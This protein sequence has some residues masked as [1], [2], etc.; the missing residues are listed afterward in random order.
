MTK[1]HSK[2]DTITGTV[3][4]MMDGSSIPGVNVVVKGSA[5]GTITDIDGRYSLDIVGEGSI[6]VFSYVG[7]STEEVEIQGRTVIDMILAESLEALNEIVVTGLS[8]ER[9][10]ESLGYSV[11]QVSGD[12]VNNVKADNFAN[13]LSG[14]V[15]GLQITESSTGVGGSSR[16]VL[17]GISSM[18]GNNRPLFVIDG[19]PMI[20]NFN[21]GNSPGKD[22]GDALADINPEDIESVTV[23]KGAG[24]AAIY[25]SRGANGV[26]LITT[27]KG[28]LNKGLGVSFNTS[29]A[30][31]EPMVMPDLQN[32][33]GQGGLG[34]RYPIVNPNITVLDHP[35]IW[36]YGPEMDGT[37]RVSWT[38]ER[39]PYVPQEDQLNYYL[40]KGNSLINNL[41]F[42]AGNENS[43]LRVSI[44]DQRDKGI[45]PNNN[46]SRQ[47]FN[48]RGFTKVKDILEI[49]GKV[50]YVHHNVENRPL[51]QENGGNAPLSFSILP[52]NISAQSLQENTV[53][54]FGNEMTWA[55][56][57]T[58]GNPYWA[59][60]NQGNYDIKDRYQ[61]AFSVK[62]NITDK[63]FLLL[64]S[65][66]DQFSLEEKSWTNKGSKTSYNGRGGYSHDLSKS[67]EWNSDFL[68]NYGNTFGKHTYGLGFGGNYR[69]NEFNTIG[70]NGSGLKIPGYYNISN[71]S[72][73][74][75]SESS[76]RKDVA[77]LYA[78]GNFSYSDILYFDFTYR[79]DWSSALPSDRNR[80]SFYSGNVSWMFTN[81]FALPR[82]ISSGKLRGSIAQ[83]G[84]D[85]GPYNLESVYGINQS[86]LPYSMVGIPGELLTPDLLPE[87]T[88][89]WEVGTDIGMFEDRLM[90]D[91]SYYYS[92]AKNQ[93][94]P[95]PLPVSTGYY[96]KRLNSGELQ[97]SG[98][99]LQISGRIL[100]NPSGFGWDMVLNYTKN[101]SNVKSINP[102]LESIQLNG[103]W[104]AV[105]LAT[106]GQEYGQIYG[107][108]YKRDEKGNMLIDEQGFPQQGDLVVHGSINPDYLFGFA[109]TFTYK[110]F[111]LNFLIDGTMGS[112]IYSWGKTYKMLW[113]TDAETLEGRAEWFDTHD[114]NGFPLPG[115]EP[116]GYI[117]PG[118]KESSGEPNTT[119]NF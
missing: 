69:I 52:R 112:E 86:P 5:S 84:N 33:Y 70:Q 48:V 78:L 109:N 64:R 17:R 12:A 95:V 2:S 23:L 41:S 3:T 72:E 119:S 10:R 50:T 60:D 98:I 115:V 110:N 1:R 65:G 105:I 27:K 62:T 63:L 6:L 20:A 103:A 14:K 107:F 104:H 96:S 75:T 116:S 118:V 80:Y 45:S 28:T 59:L 61:T 101:N 111:R 36:S 85:T 89:T 34:G 100:D 24:A 8:I 81:S 7:Y 82:F 47:T 117:F 42:D 51:L 35:N 16:V 92:L 29:F 39:V 74:Y 83:T 53:D 87:I 11:S 18:L 97:N 26:I 30:M 22:S 15:A 102:D 77:S 38:G 106:P 32:K 66:L 49:D 91:L 93:I 114:K 113:G 57:Q 37:E 108:D 25:G 19:I 46:L 99:E 13:A 76:L 58:F 43:S 9:E 71:M 68:L 54:E 56:D 90:V 40:R 31:E 94:M 4:S 88:N 55:V 67:S 73:Y 79:S 44:T 21:D